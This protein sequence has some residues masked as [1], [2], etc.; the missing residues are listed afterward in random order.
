[1]NKNSKD[2]KNRATSE[3]QLMDL[4]DKLATQWAERVEASRNKV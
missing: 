1:M 3:E 2:K 4:Y